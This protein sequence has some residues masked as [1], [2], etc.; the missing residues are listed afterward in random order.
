MHIWRLQHR[1]I[2]L[3]FMMEI[4]HN[5][6]NL[7]TISKYEDID[8]LCSNILNVFL[9]IRPLCLTDIKSVWLLW[10]TRVC[11]L[12]IC[13]VANSFIHIINTFGI[14]LCLCT[15][16]GFTYFWVH[17]IIIWSDYHFL[18]SDMDLF[19]LIKFIN[20][21]V[22]VYMYMWSSRG[23]YVLRSVWLHV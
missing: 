6:I 17:V 12:H 20:Q 19:K 21:R 11:T 8:P 16:C 4:F 15:F 18:I 3:N 22:L 2:K 9:Y 10:Y 23:A 5:K 7:I 14:F 1:Y 13:F